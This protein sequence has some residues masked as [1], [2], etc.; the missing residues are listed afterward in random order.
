M[1]FLAFLLLIYSANAGKISPCAQKPIVLG[2]NNQAK[3][4][5]YIFSFYIETDLIAGKH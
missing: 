2:V 1:I 5:D 3:S 4:S